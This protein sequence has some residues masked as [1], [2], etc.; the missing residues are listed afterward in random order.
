MSPGQIPDDVAQ[1]VK[2][3]LDYLHESI[4]QAYE[5]VDAGDLTGLTAII[6]DM[7]WFIFAI[8]QHRQRIPK[9]M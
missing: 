8:D 1:C 3:R 9:E 7:G 4:T 6:R 5:A 2:V